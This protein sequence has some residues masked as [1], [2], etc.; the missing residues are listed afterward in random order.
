MGSKKIKFWASVQT[1]LFCSLG[2]I[3][4]I[5]VLGAFGWIL[6]HDYDR[7]HK[8]FNINA[9]LVSQM[10]ADALSTPLWNMDTQAMEKLLQSFEVKANIRNSRIFATLAL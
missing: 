10:G 4:S 9:N 1:R 6:K 5:L 2:A 8:N 3:I 7:E